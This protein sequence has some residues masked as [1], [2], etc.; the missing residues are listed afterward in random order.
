M[1]ADAFVI[2]TVLLLP[3]IATACK[4]SAPKDAAVRYVS[5]DIRVFLRFEKKV[6][7]LRARVQSKRILQDSFQNCL[8]LG[9]NWGNARTSTG[10]RHQ[11]IMHT[12]I[13]SVLTMNFHEFSLNQLI[14]SLKL[15]QFTD[16]FTKTFIKKK[17]NCVPFVIRQ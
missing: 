12:M 1:L 6:A 7:L 3:L 2:Y 10:S 14:I 15:N 16:C 9:S 4:R 5:G 11:N 8:V 17:V 13:A